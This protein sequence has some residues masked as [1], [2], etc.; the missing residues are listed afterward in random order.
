MMLLR[1]DRLRERMVKMSRKIAC[2]EFSDKRVIAETLDVYRLAGL[3]VATG[4]KAAER[5]VGAPRITS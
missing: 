3:P 2:E 5:F 1:D 4:A